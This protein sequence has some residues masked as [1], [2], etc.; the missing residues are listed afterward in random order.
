MTVRHLNGTT[1]A[2]VLL[3]TV[4]CSKKTFRGRKTFLG[5]CMLLCSSHDSVDGAPFTCVLQQAEVI[6]NVRMRNV[7]E[8]SSKA[9]QQGFKVRQDAGYVATCVTSQCGTM[10]FQTGCTCHPEINTTRRNMTI[11][12]AL[13]MNRTGQCFSEGAWDPWK[14]KKRWCTKFK[15]ASSRGSSSPSLA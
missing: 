5:L 13:D 4:Q 14:K 1:A 8:G 2:V 3:A 9:S 12:G 11:N 10:H 15:K 7:Y 6:I